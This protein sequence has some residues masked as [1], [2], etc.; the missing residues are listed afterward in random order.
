VRSSSGGRSGDG[1]G[2]V[3]GRSGCN[4]LQTGSGSRSHQRLAHVS[5]KS[6][7]LSTHSSLTTPIECCITTNYT[8]SY[9]FHQ[10]TIV[11]DELT[12]LCIGTH[13]DIDARLLSKSRETTWTEAPTWLARDWLGGFVGVLA[14]RSSLDGPAGLWHA[15]RPPWVAAWVHCHS[16]PPWRSPQSLLRQTATKRAVRPTRLP[17]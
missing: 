11:V 2:T 6:I 9:S 12:G 14:S 15:L 3:G 10:N 17:V 7:S 1:R 16:R 4:P 13:A 5:A 8:F